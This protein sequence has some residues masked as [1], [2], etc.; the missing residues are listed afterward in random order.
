MW[1]ALETT[2]WRGRK[3]LKENVGE[4]FHHRLNPGGQT[5]ELLY[6]PCGYMSGKSKYK[7]EDLKVDHGKVFSGNMRIWIFAMGEV[8]GW[9]N[10][11]IPDHFLSY[12]CKQNN[13]EALPQWIPSW[14]PYPETTTSIWLLATDWPNRKLVL[15]STEF[16]LF[17]EGRSLASTQWVS[18][19]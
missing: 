12:S 1:G 13:T 17:V 19:H 15:M 10:E 11:R 3:Q 9:L 16:K 2:C 18:C 7:P 4:S 8:G 5:H 6:S 14:I